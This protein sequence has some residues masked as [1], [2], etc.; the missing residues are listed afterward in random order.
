[1]AAR[2]RPRYREAAN[3]GLINFLEERGVGGISV[4]EGGS[5]DER[6]WFEVCEV[7][8]V[9]SVLQHLFGGW[10]CWFLCS[11]WLV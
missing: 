6:L 8:V 3:A 10:L 1:M 5:G 4:E 11:L 9:G 2:V 7:W